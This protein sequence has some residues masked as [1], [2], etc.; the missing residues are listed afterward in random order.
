MPERILSIRYLG[1]AGAP[2]S[3]EVLHGRRK[4]VHGLIFHVWHEAA[5]ISL[6]LWIE[7]R[8]IGKA[9]RILYLNAKSNIT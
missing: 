5:F 7:A 8:Y 1:A 6:H 4:V 3:E 9:V 2:G